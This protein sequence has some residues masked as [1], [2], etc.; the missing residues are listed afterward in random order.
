MRQS[1]TRLAL[2][3]S[4]GCSLVVCRVARA[5]GGSPLREA[6][7]ARGVPKT[8]AYTVSL[9]VM[10]CLLVAGFVCNAAV[11]AVNARHHMKE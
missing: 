6:Q 9:Y 10:A 7:L 3:F 4:L 1:G 5:D 8:Q 2:A 11:R